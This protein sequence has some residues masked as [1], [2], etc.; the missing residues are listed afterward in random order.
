MI[1]E[2]AS[3]VLKDWVRYEH[4]TIYKKSNYE[5][6]ITFELP[7]SSNVSLVDKNL[8]YDE[9]KGLTNLQSFGARSANSAEIFES[10]IAQYRKSFG[11]GR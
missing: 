5:V 6:V 4:T 11:I 1:D 10:S 8:P 2:S 7:D 9:S 3:N